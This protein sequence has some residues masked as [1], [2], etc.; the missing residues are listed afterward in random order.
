MQGTTIGVTK[1]DARSSDYSSHGVGFRVLGS[2]S[3]VLR[4]P[5]SLEEI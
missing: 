1:E 5:R 4:L 3:R 2:G